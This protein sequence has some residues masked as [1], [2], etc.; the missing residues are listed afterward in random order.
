VGTSDNIDIVLGELLTD[1]G[2]VSD[3]VNR[4]RSLGVSALSASSIRCTVLEG[5]DSFYVI[6]PSEEN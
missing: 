2:A 3:W 6:R 4:W 5:E 1:F